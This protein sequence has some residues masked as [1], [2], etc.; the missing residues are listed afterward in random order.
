ME[1]TSE[2]LARELILLQRQE[3]KDMQ[4]EGLIP[5]DKKETFKKWLG[6]QT[7][8]EQY[9]PE[10]Q[11]HY[12]N[13]VIRKGDVVTLDMAPK[14]DTYEVLKIV[15]AFTILLKGITGEFKS[16]HVEVDASCI[17]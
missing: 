12:N 3:F 13:F 6:E 16:V 2:R 14:T 7:I 4:R 8:T 17:R 15:D 5:E 9:I 11:T 1:T 10:I